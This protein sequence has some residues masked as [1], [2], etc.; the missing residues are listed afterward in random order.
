MRTSQNSPAK[1][2]RDGL[3]GERLW[4]AIR[5]AG[6]YLYVGRKKSK[7]KTWGPRGVSR[8]GWCG[9]PTLE[10]KTCVVETAPN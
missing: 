1:L 4:Q 6:E 3:G 8:L 5:N 7:V 10:Q 2:H 9:S